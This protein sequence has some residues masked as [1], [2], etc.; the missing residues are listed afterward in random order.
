MQ[1]AGKVMTNDVKW[2]KTV[3]IWC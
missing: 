1:Y 3:V 2:Y